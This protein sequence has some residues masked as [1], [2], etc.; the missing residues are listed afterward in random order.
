MRTGG[1]F[2][3]LRGRPAPAPEDVAGMDVA[4]ER[5]AA[6]R[7]D[8]QFLISYPRSG[9]TW[10]RHLL[11]DVIVLEKPDLPAPESLWMLIPDLHVHPMDHPARDQFGLPTRIFKAHNLRDLY[12]RRFAYIFRE[13]ADSLASFFHFHLREKIAPELTAQG[14]DA[15]CVRML[16]SW[17]EHAGLAL[18]AHAAA[19]ERVALFSYEMLQKEPVPTLAA[20]ARFYGLPASAATLE[21]A[22]ELNRFETLRAKEAQSPQNPDEFFFR[23]GKV[24]AGAGELAGETRSRITA[25]AGALYQQACAAQR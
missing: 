25:E 20:I 18:E 7:A 14:L 6:L 2:S 19:P 16:P 4:P 1:W 24:G 9:N 11:R 12:R 22:V 15:F 23:K 3:W 5:L 10:V 8:D 13:P 17:C 21:K